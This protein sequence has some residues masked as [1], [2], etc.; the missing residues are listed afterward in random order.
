MTNLT[1]KSVAAI[2]I[3]CVVCSSLFAGVIIHF[4][5]G[6]NVEAGRFFDVSIDP[7]NASLVV[8]QVQSFTVHSSLPSESLNYS[9][10]Y[11]TPVNVS[12]SVDGVQAWWNGSGTFDAGGSFSFSFLTACA[13]LRLS[14]HVVENDPSSSL[15]GGCGDASAS[16]FDPYAAPSVY[17]DAFPIGTIV[18]ADG[19]GWYRYTTNGQSKYSSTNASK[20]FEFAIGNSSAGDSIFIKTGTYGP[21]YLNKDVSLI[22]EGISTTPAVYPLDP[23]DMITGMT[24][25][26]I[27][28]TTA[29]TNAITIAGTRGNIRIE[30]IG[31]HFSGSGTGIGVYSPAAHD[32]SGLMYCTLRNIVVWGHDASHYAFYLVN[33]QH[34]EFTLLYS[35]GGPAFHF[36]TNSSTLCYGISNIGLI[37]ARVP[38]TISGMTLNVINMVGG[39]N[40]SF[41]GARINRLHVMDRRI[42]STGASLY[43]RYADDCDIREADIEDTY[44]KTLINLVDSNHINIYSGIMFGGAVK[45]TG[46]AFCGY[47]GGYIR[48][49]L[50]NITTDSGTD[51]IMPQCDAKSDV[52]MNFTRLIQ[53]SNYVVYE[54]SG[55]FYATCGLSG[56]DYSHTSARWVLQ[57]VVDALPASGGTIT[58]H[59]ADYVLSSTWEIN[60]NYVTVTGWG[61]QDAGLA[62]LKIADNVNVPAITVSGS[63]VTLRDLTIDGNK[64]VESATTD[65]ITVTGEHCLF[66]RLFVRNA[67]RYG[68]SLSGGGSSNVFRDCLIL[69]AKKYG[70]YA[71]GGYFT[72]IDSCE[73]RDIG[74]SS[75]FTDVAGVAFTGIGVGGAV[76]NCRFNFIYSNVSGTC[77]GYGI[78][79][80]SSTWDGMQY[81]SNSGYG[82]AQGLFSPFLS[83]SSTMTGNVYHHTGTVGVSEP[84][85]ST[86]GT[87]EA[88]SYLVYTDGSS[89]FMRNG[90]TGRIDYSGANASQ[91][92]AN[93]LNNM[94]SGTIHFGLGV[95]RFTSNITYTATGQIIFEG[96][97][98]PECISYGYV[99]STGGTV[100]AFDGACLISGR[101]GW[102][103][104]FVFRDL[105]IE[106]GG[107]YSTKDYAMKFDYTLLECS[108]VGWVFNGEFQDST[109]I[110][111]QATAGP[112]ANCQIWSD[113]FISDERLTGQYTYLFHFSTENGVFQNFG[114]ILKPDLPNGWYNLFYLH[115]S[116]DSW[117]TLKHWNFFM[118]S[119]FW[120]GTGRYQMFYGD[121]R[122][123][124]ENVELVPIA[125]CINSV[126][127]AGSFACV[128]DINCEL[129]EADVPMRPVLNTGLGYAQNSGVVTNGT[130]TTFTITHHLA[131][132]PTWV[133]ISFNSTNIDSAKWTTTSTTITVTVHN[134]VTTDQVVAC[135]WEAKYVP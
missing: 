18:E 108:N 34:C 24:G 82:C 25:V 48:S 20:V 135:Y 35:F 131:S 59:A 110:V 119:S 98:Q 12:V 56:M 133:G 50:S 57:S 23:D 100:L 130:A 11:Y 22:G 13:G 76:T 73:F 70:I 114:F 33:F 53:E 32:Q 15:Y 84:P 43:M 125:H 4:G 127:I 68:V 102:G 63:Y 83:K 16:V 31:I 61:A 120:S 36:A 41:A 6:V 118:D 121:G 44:P 93:V 87:A 19:A 29:S 66:E 117:T 55:T 51:F 80:L 122:L 132:T 90:S 111:D 123:R 5:K 128:D 60:K 3:L 65:A 27:S 9:W 86:V 113:V 109:A 92:F 49:Y 134:R 2:A 126:H 46:T 104:N 99:E 45:H 26:V 101:I 116:G 78:E 10:S 89:Y 77:Y 42:E 52:L 88:Y 39:A 95:F 69:G 40:S 106:I 112:P 81:T 103:N 94:T 124:M 8:G 7:S 1:K 30:N 71:N 107:N 38:V 129:L 28:I 79:E 17:L 21:I 67:E 105:A 85:T 96:E 75:G 14:V 115:G 72:T 47:W 54:V 97:G 74:Q 64:G 58:L 37:Y 91:I 62:E